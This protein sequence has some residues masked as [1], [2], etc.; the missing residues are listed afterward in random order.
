MSKDKATP[1]FGRTTNN[2]RDTDEDRKRRKEALRRANKD[3]EEALRKSQ[4]APAE[5]TTLED[6]KQMLEKAE[7]RASAM[8][9]LLFSLSLDMDVLKKAVVGETAWEPHH[10]DNDPEAVD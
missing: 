9:K 7:L 8:E 1:I 3:Y 2:G 10:A 6:L 4:G 5:E